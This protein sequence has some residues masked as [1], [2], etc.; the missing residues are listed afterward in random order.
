[1]YVVVSGSVI[2][3][4][5]KKSY[6]FL[7]NTK[8]LSP[9]L[10]NVFVDTLPL[11]TLLPWTSKALPNPDEFL[12]MVIVG[13]LSGEGSN[14]VPKYTSPLLTKIVLSKENVWSLLHHKQLY[15]VLN[16]IA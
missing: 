15:V 9:S 2:T 14:V 11:N 5:L 10:F 1:M 3:S 8:S 12:L 6:S 7:L 13:G 16:E 4:H